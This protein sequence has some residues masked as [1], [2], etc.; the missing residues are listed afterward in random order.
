MNPDPSESRTTPESQSVR[1]DHVEMLLDLALEATF[2][3]SDALAPPLGADGLR[4]AGGSVPFAIRIPDPATLLKSA[5]RKLFVSV[6]D[7]SATAISTLN[8]MEI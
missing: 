1:D 3:A 5:R 6:A 7:P 2:P 8:L 4:R